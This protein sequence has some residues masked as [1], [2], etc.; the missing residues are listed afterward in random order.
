MSIDDFLDLSNQQLIKLP[1]NPRED[2]QIFRHVKRLSLAGNQLVSSELDVLKDM[3]SLEELYLTRNRLRYLPSCLFQLKQL[4]V[5][6]LA[7]NNLCTVTADLQALG[8]LRHLDLS[9]NQIKSLPLNI[10]AHEMPNL[11]SLN[12]SDNPIPRQLL[13]ECA[14]LLRHK[15][16]IFIASQSTDFNYCKCVFDNDRSAMAIEPSEDEQQQ[17]ENPIE[18]FENQQQEKPEQNIRHAALDWIPSPPAEQVLPFDFPSVVIRDSVIFDE[19]NINAL[20]ES[21]PP[22]PPSL[23]PFRTPV[24]K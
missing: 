9:R 7:D 15:L 5:L 10:L 6:S 23:L 3:Q 16:S 4:K 22:P 11:V 2:P 21:A 24:R 14:V 8:E 19:F 12:I 17:D 1:F 20:L 13:N 18:T